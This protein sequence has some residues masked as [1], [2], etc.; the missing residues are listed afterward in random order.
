[1]TQQERNALAM[2]E[3][4]KPKAEIPTELPAELPLITMAESVLFPGG[5]LPLH[6]QHPT[7]RALLNALA[8]RKS[9]LVAVV[10]SSGDDTRH[11]VGTLARLTHVRRAP[12]S[13]VG[14]L[15]GL[16]RIEIA[17]V[18]REEP[19]P[20]CRATR[21]VEVLG[22]NDTELAAMVLAVKRHAQT[23]AELSGDEGWEAVQEVDA[24]AAV[25]DAVGQAAR[26][27][28]PDQQRMLAEL[29]VKGRLALALDQAAR[30]QH[31]LELS[32]KIDTAVKDE[33][34]KN[35]R[36]SFLREQL[37]AI[38]QEL[39]EGGD[40]GEDVADELAERIAKAGLPED[41]EKVV[42]KE[43]SRLRSIPAQSAEHGVART[44]LEWV[45]DL[46][47][48]LSTDVDNSVAHARE[49]LD[50]DHH[51]LEKVKKRILEYLAVR[52][53]RAD[54]KGPI[55]CL[56]GPPGVGKTSLG[57]S[58][59]R[60]LGRKFVRLS[61]GGVRD[62]A[63]VRGHRRTYIGALPGRIIQS[64]KRAGAVNPVMM[65]D[66]IDKLGRG[67]GDPAAA[68]LEVLDPEQN[69]AFSDH[70]LDVAYDLSRVL[71]I[72]TANNLDTIPPPLLDRMEV[73]EL[74]GYTLDEKVAIARSHLWPKQLAEH[75]LAKDAVKLEDLVL[76][77]VVTG[78][79]REAGVRSLERR[80][81]DLCRGLAMEAASGQLAPDRAVTLAELPRLLGPERFED[82]VALRTEQPGVATGLAWTP[83]GGEVLF[84][85]ATKMPGQGRLIL[86]GQLGDVMKE[87]A[88]AALSFVRSRAEA[89]GIDPSFLDKT[90]VHLHVPAGATPKDGPSAG[91]TLTTAL[92]SLITG[93]PVRP[94][95]AMTGEVTLRGLVL[96]VG[97][98]KEKVLAAHR[99]GVKRIIIP[100]RCQKD[101]VDVPESARNELEIIPVT[102]VEE[103]LEAAL[104]RSPLRK[105]APAG[106]GEGSGEGGKKPRREAP[107]GEVRV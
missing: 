14:E 78:W 85:E 75:G 25:A 99:A 104:Q 53:L 50:A 65:L 24:P 74:P 88:Q 87:S 57:Q 4:E 30:K 60:A 73:V 100:A 86:T 38:R 34:S 59:A 55:L 97:G 28:V 66:E 49:V 29:E 58:V 68:L 2:S 20:A 13:L 102:H 77:K 23:V 71:F 11:R 81:A 70:Y 19:F 92:V 26:G 69:K 89:L 95:V 67:Q 41:V 54:A 1:M 64:M 33:V 47:W 3:T 42:R 22:G 12:L 48:V 52:G 44:W 46:P 21:L 16:S 79:T 27:S 84:V 7:E 36:E 31:I 8:E 72:A 101:L 106:G 6:I 105:K 5:R 40:D 17:E 37:R 10:A 18:L 56:V 61:L 39:G 90:D 45:L 91:V 76:A 98:V 96:P 51:G 32:R 103:V 9:D 63:E 107:V 62:E 93:I 83:F 35:R 80:L 15:Q 82:E 43:L 94:D